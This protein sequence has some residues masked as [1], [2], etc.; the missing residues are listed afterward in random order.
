MS[1]KHRESS[2]VFSGEV[3]KCNMKC[4]CKCKCKCKSKIKC[5]CILFRKYSSENTL[6]KILFRKYSALALHIALRDL[7][8]K[9]STR[10]PYVS[11][12]FLSSHFFLYVLHL[13]LPSFALAL[14]LALGDLPRKY[15]SR[16]P[17]KTPHFLALS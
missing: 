1:E 4:K 13:L 3:T 10:I 17:P 2:R 16:I 14:A 9:Y 11:L 5:K 15:S 6:Q 8:R 12:P 7:C